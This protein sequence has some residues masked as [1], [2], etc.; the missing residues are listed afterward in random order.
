MKR[1]AVNIVYVVV[2]STALIQVG[3][4]SE[5]AQSGTIE[6]SVSETR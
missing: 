2:T 1:S 3:C 6:L 4:R 5:T